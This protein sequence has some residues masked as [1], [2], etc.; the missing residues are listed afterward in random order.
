MI[1]FYNIYIY[2]LNQYSNITCTPT[3]SPTLKR[4]KPQT[5]IKNTGEKYKPKKKKNKKTPKNKRNIFVLYQYYIIL[6]IKLKP[7]IKR[8][9]VIGIDRKSEEINTGESF[10]SIFSDRSKK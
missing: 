2:A 8:N 6:Y 9:S 10:P 3:P 5:S 1:L 4:W 7:R